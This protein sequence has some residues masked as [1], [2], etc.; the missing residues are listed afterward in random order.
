MENEGCMRRPAHPP[1]DD[2]TGI[3]VDDKGDIDEA[4]PGRDA[5][6]V[7]DPQHVRRRS[8]E[9]AVDVVER[10]RCGLVAH[11]SADRLAA[12]DAF[13]AH[14]LHQAGNRAAGDLE[15]LATQPPPDLANAA[16]AEVRLK[17][18]GP[19]PSRLYP[20]L[21]EPTAGRGRRA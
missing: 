7:G 19:H 10:A 6:E 20:I 1:A 8:M 18:V 16:D 2:P 14:G 15:A 12:D 21:P 4:R 11:R 3:G 13:E 5:G 9:L 17:P